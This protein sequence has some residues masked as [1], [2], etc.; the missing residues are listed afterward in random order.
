MRMA[1]AH[2][3]N[4]HA[5]VAG[6]GRGRRVQA[7]KL[8][9]GLLLKVGHVVQ[10]RFVRR[11]WSGAPACSATPRAFS[12][13][14]GRTLAGRRPQAAVVSPLRHGPCST[15]GRPAW[16]RATSLRATKSSKPPH[17]VRSACQ[18][19][20]TS[21]SCSAPQHCAGGTVSP[22]HLFHARTP[23]GDAPVSSPTFLNGYPCGICSCVSPTRR[24]KV[25]TS[26]VPSGSG[27]ASDSCRPSASALANRHAR[28]S[29]CSSPD[30]VGHACAAWT[31]AI[32]A[33]TAR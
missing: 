2:A 24:N 32:A 30:S 18:S 23:R 1:R 17:T 9:R 21:C 7:V 26:V 20:R 25:C 11:C 33:A 5:Q 13:P 8:G 14:S 22:P 12:L 29:S 28:L 27:A 31:R 19:A 4:S 3:L 6:L 16:A 10:A 15:G